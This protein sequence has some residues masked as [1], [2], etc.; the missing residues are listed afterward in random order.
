MATTKTL[1]QLNQKGLAL[2]RAVT[3]QTLV[4]SFQHSDDLLAQPG[5]TADQRH[6][7]TT[8]RGWILEVLEERG[9]LHAIG[10][11][12]DYKPQPAETGADTFTITGAS[13]VTADADDLAAARA[14][15]RTFVVEDGE[16]SATITRDHDGAWQGRGQ[17]DVAGAYLLTVIHTPTRP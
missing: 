17:R 14:A 3:T 11:T 2:T 12:A 7:I 15:A 9:D 8:A 16:A 4:L 1:D 10:L 6:E 13:G 5:L